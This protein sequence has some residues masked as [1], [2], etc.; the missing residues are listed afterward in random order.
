MNAALPVP[1]SDTIAAIATPPGRGGVGV[2]RLSGP[3]ASAILDAL[4]HPSVPRS[5]AFTPRRLYHGHVCDSSSGRIDV[6]DEALAVLMPA[7]HSYTGEDVVE[8]HCHGS[9]VILQAVLDAALC[10]GARLAVR[11][12]F[13]RR[14][15]LNGRLD[16]AQAEAVAELIAAP[17]RGAAR[18]ALARL[19]GRFGRTIQTLRHRLE[20]LRRDLC[21]ALDF[22]DEDVECLAPE[23]FA[24]ALAEVRAVIG[25][26][27]AACERS[28]P[29]RE[30]ACVVLAGRVNAGKSSLL[31]ALLGWKRALV[32]VAPGTTRDFIEETLHLDGLPVRLVDTA[33]L[34]ETGDIVEQEGQALTHDQIDNADLVLLV[35]DAT[36]PVGEHERELLARLN[37]ERVI[38]VFNK[39][40]CLEPGAPTMGHALH[41]ATAARGIACLETAAVTGQGLDELASAIR[42][43]IAGV[44]PDPDELAPNLRQRDALRQALG[45]LEGLAAELDAGIPYDLLSVRLDLACQ[46]LAGIV[47]DIAPED[48][49]ERIFEQFCIGK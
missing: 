18:L 20:A 35:I 16:L 48:V 37:P 42:S 33:G 36:V 22:P 40:D 41:Q 47:G 46:C 6:I 27:I 25:D 30:G 9:P 10:Q 26:L 43:R 11:G 21:L 12:E 32:S 2:I 4:F 49:L 13:S 5:C 15:F 3:A 23:D 31:N 44:E 45:E 38:V 8:I 28:R 19:D 34:R 24:S 7:P 14:A 39:C 17:T 29:W 1:A